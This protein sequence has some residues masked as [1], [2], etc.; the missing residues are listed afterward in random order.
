MSND[1]GMVLIVSGPSGSGKSSI[2]AEFLKRRS[3]F[4]LSISHTT[5]APRGSEQD[6]VE[7]YFVSKSD[8][9]DM[10]GRGEMLEWAEVHGNRYGT[11]R[12][13]VDEIISSGTGV[14]LEIDVQGALQVKQQ[15]QGD[16]VMVFVLPERFAEVRRRLEAR[17]T[18]SANQVALRMKNATDE[19]AEAKKYDYVIIN[20]SGSLEDAVQEL[21]SIVSAEKARPSRFWVTYEKEFWED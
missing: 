6:G 4:G 3:D 16:A 12:R 18:D 17:E 13:K 2:V 10:A 1:R 15:L 14:I 19:I 7:Y 5:R 8:F 9:D 20:R 11:S 21:V